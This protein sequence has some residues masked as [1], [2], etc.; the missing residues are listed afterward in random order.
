MERDGE[1]EYST[2]WHG[3]GFMIEAVLKIKVHNR[4]HFQ[5]FGNRQEI[6]QYEQIF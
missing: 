3:T 2:T 1:G 6:L 4:F 5:I